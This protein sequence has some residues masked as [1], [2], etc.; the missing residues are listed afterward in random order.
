MKFEMFFSVKDILQ[1]IYATIMSDYTIYINNNDDF[2]LSSRPMDHDGK[3]LHAF[4]DF[5]AL[6][7]PRVII[8]LC[9]DITLT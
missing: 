8:V 5:N 1:I 4:N 6:A 2:C 3:W 7:L 9:A